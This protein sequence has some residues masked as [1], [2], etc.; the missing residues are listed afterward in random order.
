MNVG[1]IPSNSIEDFNRYFDKHKNYLSDPYDAF[2]KTYLLISSGDPSSTSELQLLKSTN[3]YIGNNIIQPPPIGGI[4][5]HLYKTANPL[6]NF[7]PYTDEQVKKYI[8]DGGLFISYIGH[9]GTQ[10]WDNGINSIDQLKNNSGKG[11]LISDWGCSTGKFAE[12]DIKAFSEL[13]INEPDGQAIGYTGNSSLGFTSTATLFPK[14]F[15]SE[16]LQKNAASIGEAHRL[17]KMELLSTYGNTGVYR[18][19]DL[20]NVLLG[21]PIIRLKFLKNQIL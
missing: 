10:V 21:D 20:C 2:N 4:V 6:T 15:Y 19:F 9:S 13:F 5:N 18:I 16:L 11:S 8:G 14:L 3:D 12:P 17:A 1:R 7:G